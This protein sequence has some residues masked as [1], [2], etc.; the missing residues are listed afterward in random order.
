[1]RKNKQINLRGKQKGRRKGYIP[2]L[3]I[4]DADDQ[5]DK[6]EQQLQL[7]FT[8]TERFSFFFLFSSILYFLKR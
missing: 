6:R 7:G 3:N 1:M 5:A 2:E 4:N 8:L